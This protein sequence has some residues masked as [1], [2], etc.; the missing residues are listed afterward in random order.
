LPR[1]ITSPGVCSGMKRS[2]IVVLMGLLLAL[3]LSGNALATE[4]RR[5]TVKMF[6]GGGKSWIKAPRA[7]RPLVSYTLA[8][9]GTSWGVCGGLCGEIVLKHSHGKSF[10]IANLMRGQKVLRISYGYVDKTG[11]YRV[12]VSKRVS[13]VGRIAAKTTTRIEGKVR[14]MWLWHME[15]MVW[16]PS[17]APAQ[18]PNINV[19]V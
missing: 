9:A 15:V 17:Y 19:T 6:Y 13:R 8:N 12:E 18:V 16:D 3:A 7:R 5:P 1:E 11:A 10:L 14:T 2:G 4:R